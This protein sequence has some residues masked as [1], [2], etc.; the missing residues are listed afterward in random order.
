M[1]LHLAAPGRLWYPY[2]RSEGVYG[3]YNG[4]IKPFFKAECPSTFEAME[5]CMEKTMGAL[6]QHGQIA[7]DDEPW[8]R[9][10]L[11]EAL[12][13]AIRHGNHCEPKRKVKI[14]LANSQDSC[15]IR[16]YDE[17]A[18]FCPDQVAPPDC[19]QLGGRGVCLIRHFM[20]QVAYNCDKHRLEMTY[21]RK[22]RGGEKHNG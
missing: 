17:G 19:D 1:R 4:V 11:E 13:N 14:E 22:T 20:D 16:V 15:T 10:C 8:M 12:V 21:H 5:A 6:H 3:V 9:L 2:F 18:G 7:R